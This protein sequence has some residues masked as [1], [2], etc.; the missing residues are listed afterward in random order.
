MVEGLGKYILTRCAV[1]S[2][3]PQSSGQTENINL[4]TLHTRILWINPTSQQ[5][6]FDMEV[7]L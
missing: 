4:Y 1:L 7:I 5:V 2:I 3:T 6:R